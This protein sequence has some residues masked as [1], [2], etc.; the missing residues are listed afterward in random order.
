MSAASGQV[1]L[2]AEEAS[3][4]EFTRC[5]KSKHRVQLFSCSPEAA[6]G[7]GQRVK[8]VSRNGSACTAAQRGLRRRRLRG[9]EVVSAGRAV[10]RVL[11][12]RGTA[13][14]LSARAASACARQA[15]LPV[16]PW[17]MTSGPERRFGILYSTCRR[18][19][20]GGGATAVAAAAPSK[21][22]RAPREGAVGGVA[23]VEG[24]FTAWRGPGRGRR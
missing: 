1:T 22:R 12:A 11:S 3:R 2:T 6:R 24:G 4:P 13:R 19:A 7:D 9:R 23:G 16:P 14:V 10:L 17:T 15:V 8:R 5:L 21:T 20:R 18:A